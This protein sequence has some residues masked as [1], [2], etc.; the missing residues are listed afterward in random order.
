MTTKRATTTNYGHP[1]SQR[2]PPDVE[3][4]LS[5]MLWTPYERASNTDTS[6]EDEDEQLHRQQLRKSKSQY[7]YTSIPTIPPSPTPPSPKIMMPAANATTTT[8]TSS[9]VAYIATPTRI[10]AL[11]PAPTTLQVP[12]A[13]SFVATSDCL[14][15]GGGAATTT[16]YATE[17][18]CDASVTTPLV[19]F[20]S[21]LVLDANSG[22]LAAMPTP[23]ALTDEV[24]AGTSATS[25]LLAVAV[26]DAHNNCYP[27]ESTLASNAT[28]ATSFASSLES[29]KNRF[30]SY[31]SYGRLPGFSKWFSSYYSSSSSNNQANA[32]P[33]PA[34]HSI[35]N[36]NA[37]VTLPASSSSSSSSA[38]MCSSGIAA[39]M[40]SAN[41]A[42]S[43]SASE[44]KEPP[45]Y[46]SLYSK[47]QQQQQ[48]QQQQR[49][50]RS[51]TAIT[52]HSKHLNIFKPVLE[53]LKANVSTITQGHRFA[54]I[55]SSSSR[56]DN[57]SS[58]SRRVNANTSYNVVVDTNT[59]TNNSQ[60]QGINSHSHESHSRHSNNPCTVGN[61]CNTDGAPIAT[62]L[63]HSFSD[64]FLTE[65]GS[66]VQ[67]RSQHVAPLNVDNACIVNTINNNSNVINC[68]I[69]TIEESI[70]P[71]VQLQQQQT[72]QLQQSNNDAV[73]EAELIHRTNQLLVEHGRD[74]NTSMKTNSISQQTDQQE[75]EQE[76]AENKQNNNFILCHQQ[77][78]HH[79]L[80]HHYH[81]HHL[82]NEIYEQSKECD[83]MNAFTTSLQQ[84]NAALTLAAPSPHVMFR[85]PREFM[86]S[87]YCHSG[88]VGAGSSGDALLRELPPY[89]T[90]TTT[91]VPI[92]LTRSFEV[93]TTY[94]GLIG[95]SSHYNTASDTTFKTSFGPIPAS[96]KNVN[97]SETTTT[98]T[99]YNLTPNKCLAELERLYAEFRASES[100]REKRLRETQGDSNVRETS[101]ATTGQLSV[102]V[103][104][105][106]NNANM[107]LN[108]PAASSNGRGAMDMAEAA[109]G[110]GDATTKLNPSTSSVFLTTTNSVTALTNPCQR[111]PSLT[112]QVNQQNSSG[113]AANN[114][115]SNNNNNNNNNSNNNGENNASQ[116]VLNQAIV[117]ATTTTTTTTTTKNG[118][119][120]INC[121]YVNNTNNINN[122]NNNKSITN[123][124]DIATNTNLNISH[125]NNAQVIATN[126]KSSSDSDNSP[127]KNSKKNRS[128]GNQFHHTQPHHSS[129][130]QVLN[131]ENENNNNI[132]NNV[133]NKSTKAN[134]NNKNTPNNNRNHKNSSPPDHGPN[135]SV[136]VIQINGQTTSPSRTFTSTECQ[137]D[138]LSS[139][140]LRSSPR[141]AAPSTALA[142]DSTLSNSR[143]QRRRERRERRHLQH[144]ASLMVAPS[145]AHHAARHAH[146]D[147]H[148]MPAPPL[149]PILHPPHLHPGLAQN[150]HNVA[151]LRP[152]LPDILHNHYPP[153]YSALPSQP[154]PPPPSMGVSASMSGHPN[155]P[156]MQQFAHA[157]PPPPAG[158]VTL[159]GPPPPPPPAGTTMLTS[160]I[161]TVPIPGATPMVSDGRFTLPLPIMRRSPS[162]RSGKGCCGQWF[163][164]PPLRALIAVVALGGVACALGGAA[165]GATGLAGP[166]SSH[167]TAALLMIG[168]GVVLVTVSGAAWRMTAPGGPPCLGLGSSVDLG[169][170]GRRPCS[171]GGGAPQGLLYPEFQH[172]PPPPSY[173]ASMQEYRLRLL[174][175]DRDRQNGVVR[176]SSPPPTY[177]SHAGSLLRAPLTS[178]IRGAGGIGIGSATGRAESSIG[179][180]EYSFPPSYRSRNTTPGTISSE[181]SIETEPSGRLLANED[182]P[183]PLSVEQLSEYNT[184]QQ[185][186]MQ[187]RLS[188]APAGA[189]TTLA[190]TTTTTT[191]T[192][193]VISSSIAANNGRANSDTHCKHLKEEKR[194]SL[195]LDKNCIISQ[196]E[197]SSS[198]DKKDD[199][200]TIVTITPQTTDNN[201]AAD[202]VES[203]N[204]TNLDRSQSSGSREQIEILAHL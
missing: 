101:T 14:R 51:A 102:S 34:P 146:L 84:M 26:E 42:M 32:T 48:Q 180:S 163:A 18:L 92:S 198:S 89:E 62:H 75:E 70:E 108:V 185:R 45:S 149:P 123:L 135:G 152:M 201:N 24:L 72:Q 54:S 112:I 165:L 184:L 166:P 141:S 132:H 171:R 30:S 63:V 59:N 77:R 110:G 147:R 71:T 194:N 175:L 188:S 28:M 176:G 16:Y 173:Q 56:Q 40:A 159:L 19:P 140:Q 190:T 73:A 168:V 169:R 203:H 124:S 138:D 78:P 100:L 158:G 116:I 31:P 25:H 35:T 91:T 170:C 94:G 69:T 12:V 137:T 164:G 86:Y 58:S 87:V 155:G 172:R 81:H 4:A 120:V 192:A 195:Q 162:E 136:N 107:R 200:V 7:D 150:P 20:S 79:H 98:T 186:T 193:A 88:G 65:H 129:V 38:Q 197:S 130:P 153:P 118:V 2:R 167:F 33:M 1:H 8:S 126:P 53:T 151:M 177:R 131:V 128:G 115:D 133:D 46:E 174:L 119:S 27:N 68:S 37:T 187:R 96:T 114:N 148:S 80:H 85:E 127:L 105:S 23:S 161:S 41:T 191:T 21:S 82:A 139:V 90:T 61:R 60:S 204:T 93:N 5:S 179:G 121:N 52:R 95:S 3:E 156:T 134:A 189:T 106:E 64:D 66:T 83:K 13:A 74:Q 36:D 97:S 196:R 113:P 15:S 43:T 47:Q 144:T 202:T 182:I 117:N 22:N 103:E 199:L 109:K 67:R 160:V 154:P 44:A 17:D 10:V 9:L 57:S 142:R 181:R 39:P 183:E 157:C 122:N 76:T 50:R 55:S 178:T 145:H 29:H 125:V 111:T 104:S 49:R 6:S 143:D 99:T 11:Q